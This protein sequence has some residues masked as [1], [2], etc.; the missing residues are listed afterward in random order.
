M[1]SD[2][3]A[4]NAEN[5]VKVEEK[6][7]DFIQLIPCEEFVTMQSNGH[8]SVVKEHQLVEPSTS[9]DS[10][11]NV[12]KEKTFDEVPDGS[13]NRNRQ[14]DICG[15]NFQFPRDLKTHMQL[16]T[17]EKPFS[18]SFCGRMH[19]FPKDLKI[20]IM[21]IHTGE[22]PFSCSFCDKKF[23]TSHQ[24]SDVTKVSYQNVLCVVEDIY[25]YKR[26]C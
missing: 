2:L 20:H 22:K 13:C 5:F 15:K 19:R 23:V 24:M 18:C 4:S 21:R 14:C 26:T 12:N 25:V 11:R 1:K 16:H 9:E 7:E 3:H 10:S 6:E 8:A 17:G